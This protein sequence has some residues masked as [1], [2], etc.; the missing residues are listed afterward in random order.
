MCGKQLKIITKIVRVAAPVFWTVSI[1]SFAY[2]MASTKSNWIIVFVLYGIL[3][4]IIDLYEPGIFFPWFNGN[5]LGLFAYSKLLKLKYKVLSKNPI[6]DLERFLFFKKGLLGYSVGRSWPFYCLGIIYSNIVEFKS[7]NSPIHKCV[8]N[9]NNGRLL[10]VCQANPYRVWHSENPYLYRFKEPTISM[11]SLSEANSILE[12]KIN[13]YTT[14]EILILEEN[15]MG[16]NQI[17]KTPWIFTKIM[18]QHGIWYVEQ[19]E[20]FL[21]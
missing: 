10:Y 2:L 3:P 12:Q 20:N 16:I 21:K 14:E 13:F 19:K 1:F 11:T 17:E 7:F 9:D 4:L 8:F 15:I 5:P 18:D 6:T